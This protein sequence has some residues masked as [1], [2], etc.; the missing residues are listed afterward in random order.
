MIKTELQTA[1]AYWASYLVNGD[2]SGLDMADRIAAHNFAMACGG[3]IVA[4]GD[5]EFF[6]VRHDALDFYPVAAMCIEYVIHLN[7]EA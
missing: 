6:S 2:H 1:P 3:A 4:C 7:A 5:D